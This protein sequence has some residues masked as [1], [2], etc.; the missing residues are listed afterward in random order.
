MFTLL[1]VFHVLICILLVVT[2]LLQ[3]GKGAEIGA[4]FGSSEALFGSS[5]PVTFL[6]KVTTVLAA[7]FMISSLALTYVGAH[8]GSGSIMQN[9]V[10]TMPAQQ[11]PNQ[12]GKIAPHSGVPAGNKSGEQGSKPVKPNVNSVNSKAESGGNAAAKASNA[13]D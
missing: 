10:K 5:G 1:I 3:Q 8:R 2:V 9:V 11:V 7:L 6:N 13:T 4:V 12:P